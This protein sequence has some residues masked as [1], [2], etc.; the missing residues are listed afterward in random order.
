MSYRE[1]WTQIGD[2]TGQTWHRYA[3]RAIQKRIGK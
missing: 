2:S 1:Q 3:M